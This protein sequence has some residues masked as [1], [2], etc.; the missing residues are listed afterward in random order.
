MYKSYWRNS[1]MKT[2]PAK[3]FG[4]AYIN[5][6]CYLYNKTFT[7][8]SAYIYIHQVSSLV[9]LKIVTH[10]YM[11]LWITENLVL[12]LYHS[13]NKKPPKNLC[14][15]TSCNRAI[16]LINILFIFNNH[17]VKS[18]LKDHNVGFAIPTVVHN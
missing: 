10:V 5:Y 16:E 11:K 4:M 14:H 18:I 8:Y 7:K 3:Y 6:T 9:R 1:T 12:F 2:E 15:V 17:W 13:D